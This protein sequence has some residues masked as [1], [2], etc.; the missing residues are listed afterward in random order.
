MKWFFFTLFLVLFLLSA[1]AA[2][3]VA[4]GPSVKAH[5]ESWRTLISSAIS[6]RIIILIIFVTLVLTSTSF[7]LSQEFLAS[8][9]LIARQLDHPDC[10]PRVI[11]PWQNDVKGDGGRLLLMLHTAEIFYFDRYEVLLRTWLNTSESVFGLKVFTTG[12]LIDERM[13]RV[14]DRVRPGLAPEPERN[15][16]ERNIQSLIHVITHEPVYDWYFKLDDDTFLNIENMQALLVEFEERYPK[17]RENPY[18]VGTCVCTN[19]RDEGFRG[20]W[21]MF[22]CTPFVNISSFNYACG[23]AGYFLSRRALEILVHYEQTV[24]LHRSAEDLSIGYFMLRMNV[25]C[26]HEEQLHSENEPLTLSTFSPSVWAAAVTAHK[27]NPELM[28]E[29]YRRFKTHNWT[30]A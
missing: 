23:G 14:S 1:G 17:P 19:P 27:V 7:L 13:V 28:D 20:C 9:S 12:G 6:C 15:M 3:A 5:S 10:S 11:N 26:S 21:S 4:F 30:V 16:N 18:Y 29:V 2:F 8:P 22:D 25:S 24:G